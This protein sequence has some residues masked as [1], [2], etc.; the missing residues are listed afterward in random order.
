VALIVSLGLLGPAQAEFAFTTLD[1]PGSTAT[2]PGTIK[3]PICEISV[4]A[5]D[6]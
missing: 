2:F 3:K 5:Q 4:V 6:H 1:S